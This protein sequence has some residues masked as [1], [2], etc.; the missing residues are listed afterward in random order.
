MKYFICKS[1]RFKFF[2]R[3]LY[4]WWKWENEWA[5][6]EEWRATTG[7]QQTERMAAERAEKNEAKFVDLFI[8]GR[9]M[10]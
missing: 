4:I 10:V 2:F 6:E 8:K 7:Q 1:E 3:R 5:S 9:Q